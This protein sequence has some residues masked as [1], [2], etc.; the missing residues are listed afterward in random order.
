[1]KFKCDNVCP[2]PL[3]FRTFL[4]LLVIFIFLGVFYKIVSGY[5]E[6]HVGFRVATEASIRG[7]KSQLFQA[8]SSMHSHM[9]PCMHGGQVIVS[10]SQLSPPILGLIGVACNLSACKGAPLS[11]S[12]SASPQH[13]HFPCNGVFSMIFKLVI[14]MKYGKL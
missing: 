9:P 8:C 10:G 12:H 4:T 14:Y 3:F 6:N 5:W 13:L 7:D 11:L 1:M 2:V